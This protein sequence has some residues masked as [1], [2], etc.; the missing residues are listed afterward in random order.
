MSPEQAALATIIVSLFTLLVTIFGWVFTGRLQKQLLERQIAADSEREA[1]QHIIPRRLEE[2]E[3]LKSWFKQGAKFANTRPFVK[4]TVS[5]NEI[6]QQRHDW[7]TQG[8]TFLAYID[9]FDSTPPIKMEQ[10]KYSLVQL[11]K[12]YYAGVWNSLGKENLDSDESDQL[13][14]AIEHILPA[15]IKKID[16]LIEQTA[17]NQQKSKKTE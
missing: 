6:T 8:Q 1:R 10:M 14:Y 17:I 2:L 12:R 5:A 7:E 11:I 13:I 9:Q 15:A 4:G 16:G 3:N